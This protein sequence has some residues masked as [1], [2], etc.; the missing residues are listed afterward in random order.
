MQMSHERFINN[1][2]NL[3]NQRLQ[4]SKKREEE[5]QNGEP[6]S[7]G[8][9]LPILPHNSSQKKSPKSSTPMTIKKKDD[10]LLFKATDEYQD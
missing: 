2:K 4:K 5:Y 10:N 8:T 1:E 9:G 3:S 7:A 6:D